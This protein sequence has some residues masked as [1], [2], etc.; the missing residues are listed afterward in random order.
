MIGF[1]SLNIFYVNI[2]LNK[3]SIKHKSY[4]KSTKINTFE[5]KICIC[6]SPSNYNGTN[7]GSLY[8]KRVVFYKRCCTNIF[9]GR[10]LL[11]T[12]KL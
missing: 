12:V 6:H 4:P 10:L 2:Y 3:L 5:R 8:Q 1:Q 7:N 11:Y 9:D